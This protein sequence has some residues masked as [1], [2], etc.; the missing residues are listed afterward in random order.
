MIVLDGVYTIGQSDKAKFHRVPAPNQAEIQKL[1]NRVIKRVVR[2]LERNGLLIADH[3][4]PWLDLDFNEPMDTVSAASSARYRIAIGP[5]PAT[6]LSHC[7]TH[8]LS[9]QTS[10]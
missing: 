6:A 8:H 7:M 2:R 4:Q 1:L 3:E 9:E 10:L 5:I